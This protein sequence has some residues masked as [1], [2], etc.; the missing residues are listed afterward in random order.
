MLLAAAVLSLGVAGSLQQAQPAP[1]DPSTTATALRA[2]VAPRIDGLGNDAA[3]ANAPKTSNFLEFDPK[4]SQPARHRTEFQVT[5][6]D[7]NL[8]VFVRAYDPHPDSIMHALTRRDVRGPSDQIKLIIDSY[9]D[10]RTGFEFAVNPDGVKRDYAVFEDGNEDITWN[11][12]WDVATSVDEQGWTAEFQI[13]LSQLRYASATDHT[14][15]FGIWRDIERYRE[16]VSWPE[17]KVA[18]SGFM[19]QMGNL[20]GLTELTSARRME[21]TPYALTKNVSRERTVGGFEREQELSIGGDLKLGLTPNITL[22]ATINPDFGQVEADPAVLNLSAFETFVSE[23]R[24]FFVEGTGIYT[25]FRLNCYIV[26]D[27]STNEGLFY[28]RRIGR[29]PL[30]RDDYGDAA[31]PTSTPIAAAA[32]LT[33]RTRS[34]SSG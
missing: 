6:D 18:T 32:K 31:T 16:R 23:R 24:P 5:Y 9:N 21:V 10:N 2:S 13:P 27:C 25:S 29:S 26:V 20:V 1:R 7:R 11:G 34:G 3:W 19:S 15:G 8:Y 22:D 14:F 33:G 17:Y 4:P 30:L 12:I 28:S